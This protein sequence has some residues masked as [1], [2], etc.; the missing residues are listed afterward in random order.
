MLPSVSLT[1]AVVDDVH[2]LLGFAS[3]LQF[4]PSLL[5]YLVNDVEDQ[6]EDES[7]HVHQHCHP[8]GPGNGV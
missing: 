2:D 3:Q 6:Y 5:I 8:E 7:G 1:V 4:L